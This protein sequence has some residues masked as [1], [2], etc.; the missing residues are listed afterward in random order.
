MKTITYLYSVENAG[1]FVSHGCAD[2]ADY[3]RK[4]RQYNKFRARLLQKIER[5]EEFHDNYKG[6]IAANLGGVN[7]N[8]QV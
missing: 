5:L 1:Y 8:N 7:E 3:P 6:Y 2:P 4:F